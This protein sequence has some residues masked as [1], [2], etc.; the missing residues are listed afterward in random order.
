LHGIADR[1][2]AVGYVRGRS[3]HGRDCDRDTESDADASRATAGRVDGPDG[4]AATCT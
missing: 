4:A 2:A 1:A 3:E